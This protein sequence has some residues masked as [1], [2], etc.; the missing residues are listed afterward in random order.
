MKIHECDL[1]DEQL[2]SIQKE[3]TI[4]DMCNWNEEKLNKQHH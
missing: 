2:T 1:D 4:G 3:I